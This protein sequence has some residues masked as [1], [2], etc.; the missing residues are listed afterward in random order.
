MEFPDLNQFLQLQKHLWQ[1][2]GS[3]ASIMIGAGLSLNSQPLP[4][5]RT[6]FPTW[7]ALRRRMFDEIYPVQAGATA[8]E[9]REREQ[10][11]KSASV[12]RIASKYEASFERQRLKSFLLK[13]IPDLDHA[14]GQI[15]SLLLQLPWNDVFTTNYDTL[16]ERTDVPGR[17]YQPVTTVNDLTDA[18]SPRIIKL[19]GSFSSLAEFTIT[20]EDYRT[21]PK[22]FAPFVNTVRQALIENA[23]VLVGFSGDDPNFLEWIGWIRDEL[24]DAH[25]PIY[26]VGSLSLDEIERSLLVKRGVTPIDLTPVVVN[27]RPGR[28]THAAALEW[29][30]RSLLALKPPRSDKWPKPISTSRSVVGLGQSVVA[31]SVAEPEDVNEPVGGKDGLDEETVKKI[32]A[33]WHY[34]RN[35]YPGWLVPTNEI[36]SSLWRKTKKYSFVLTKSV[37]DWPAVDRVLLFREITWRLETSMLPHF[38]NLT[39]PFESTINDLFPNVQNQVSLRNLRDGPIAEDVA[40]ADITNAWLEVAFGLLRDARESYDS[41]RWNKLWK[42][43]EAVVTHCPQFMD[44]HHYEH[45]LWMVWNL[46]RNRAKEVLANWSPSSQSPVAVMWKAGLMAEMDDLKE[47]QSLL[48]DALRAIRQS[49]RNSSGRNIGLL[50]VE[51]WCTYLL[52]LV[53]GAMDYSKWR[54]IRGE[55]SER[56]K[57]LRPWDCDPWLLKQS[58][59]EVVLETPPKAQTGKQVIRSF[60]PGRANVRYQLGG[61]SIEPRLPAFACIRLYEQAGIP[62]RMLGSTIGGKAL[63][64]ACRWIAP[65]VEFWSPAI[66]VRTGNV[67]AL[68]E[69]G[70]MSRV[71]V[72]DMPSTLTQS[73]NIWAMSALRQ[74]HSL[75]DERGSID[76]TQESL[77]KALI[78]VVSRLAFRLESVELQEAFSLA[79][80]IQRD[81]DI[82]S[83]ITLGE[84]CAAWFRRLFETATDQ[85]IL[86][87]LPGLIGSPLHAASN[88]SSVA[89]HNRWFDPV[90]EIPEERTSRAAGDCAPTLLVAI[91]EANVR[92]LQHTDSAMGEERR[93]A[94]ARLID[95]FFA[96]VMSQEDQNRFAAILWD[97]TGENGLPEIPDLLYANYLQLPKPDEVDVASRVKH[98]LKALALT[99]I[100]NDGSEN[101]SVPAEEN[102]IIQEIASVSK[103]IVQIPNEPKGIIE[104]DEDE[105]HELW[106]KALEWWSDAK[107]VL[108]IERASPFP[109]GRNQILPFVD[110]FGMFLAR[111]VL[112]KMSMSEKDEWEKVL[113]I[114]SQTRNYGAYLT[115]VLPYTLLHCSGQKDQVARAILDDL[116]AGDEKAVESSAMAVRHWIHLAD[117]KL[118]DK[119]PVKVVNALIWRVV[120]RRPEKVDVCM[121]LLAILLMEK[122]DA[123]NLDQVNFIVAGLQPWNDATSLSVHEQSGGDFSSDERPALRVLLGR[124]ASA[125]SIWLRKKFPNE[126][127]PAEISSLRE[128]FEKNRLPEIRRAF[129]TWQ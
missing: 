31:S 5:I 123:F 27:Q 11:F 116:S 109:L 101:T 14:P 108:A 57:E 55:F 102:R 73:L 36:R 129:D 115:T 69:Q 98:C 13:E 43:I 37:T 90:A 82:A 70:F 1:W 52:Y 88:Q 124:L 112:P 85:Q 68:S 100:A 25:A 42:K 46:Q 91:G 12:L 66:L 8:E 107:S 83:H 41:D 121:F 6:S 96:G 30:A 84:S 19:H 23:F 94:L 81:P 119:P 89:L 47:A 4:G 97:K 65:L 78:E 28:E 114:L 21:Y 17:A 35:R 2:P 125:A 51:G 104:W 56:W 122:P 127:E 54:E 61:N 32:F 67:K 49:L 80:E 7:D 87:W 59:D 33:R 39:S 106:I 77:L 99:K 26:L 74:E 15:H 10:K 53:E 93:R 20:E 50:S 44:R 58:L 16:L 105:A 128:S 24:G 63:R 72:A 62:M 48:R 64:N 126:E 103:P 117:A 29:F 40:D 3:R 71:Q 118:V 113:A 76:S 34:E 86:E 38:S 92:L 95:I 18:S 79:L 75:L 120:L 110:Y 60:D 22:R 111:A 45:A 9:Q